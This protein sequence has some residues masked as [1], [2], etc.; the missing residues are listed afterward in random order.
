MK[1]LNVRYFHNF[2]KKI[3]PFLVISLAIVTPYALYQAL[4]L[5][6]EDYQQGNLVRIMYVHVPAAW[7]SLMIYSIIGLLSICTIIWNIPLCYIIS[8]SLA[9]IGASFALITLITGSIWGQTT[10]GTWWV[11]D[12][13]L[14]SMMILLLLYIGYISIT[15]IGDNLFRA[16]KPASIFAILGLINIPIV[17][18]SV[19]LWHSLHQPASL[20][21]VDGPA[22]DVKMLKPLL[23]MFLVN[24][25]YSMLLA[26]IKIQAILSKIKL[27][28]IT[29]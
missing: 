24:L 19:N 9:P 12:A 25:L 27:N 5:S 20:I 22:I 1:I 7:M 4:F 17:K 21:R 10:W 23:L 18:F 29:N 11:W 15:N 13:R 14:T 26:N 2:I 8:I 6:P 28:K 16:E 3:L